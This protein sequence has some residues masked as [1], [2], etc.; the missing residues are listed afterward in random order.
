MCRVEAE[1]STSGFCDTGL[2]WCVGRPP[3]Q[4]TMMLLSL[5]GWQGDCW[6]MTGYSEGKGKLGCS[7]YE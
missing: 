2:E 4:L 6:D 5:P 1:A 7:K 3:A